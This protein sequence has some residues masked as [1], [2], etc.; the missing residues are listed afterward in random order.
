L[1]SLAAAALLVGC[2]APSKLS[3]PPAT[4]VTKALNGLG[5]LRGVQ[6]V[7]QLQAAGLADPS[8]SPA[9]A[10]A[11]LATHLVVTV[12]TADGRSLAGEGS[13]PHPEANIDVALVVRGD[14]VAELRTVAHK[15]YGRIDFPALGTQLALPATQRSALAHV[16]TMLRQDGTQAPGLANLA[17]GQWVDLPESQVLSVGTQQLVRLGIPLAP[18]T[19]RPATFGRVVASIMDV[20][21]RSSAADTGPVKG[22]ESYSASLPTRDL[23]SSPLTTLAALAGTFGNSA[24]AERVIGAAEAIPPAATVQVNFVVSGNRVAE[25]RLPLGQLLPNNPS[26]KDA[27][28]VADVSPAADVTVPSPST[29]LDLVQLLRGLTQRVGG[30]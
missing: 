10:Q 15:V 8:L 12:H 18:T 29:P 20:I 5:Q 27:Q 28:I 30:V 7:V 21:S 26:V 24:T 6:A 17:A 13:S 1:A 4:V 25:G 19:L 9:E 11:I 16:Q 22:G 3:G 14:N 2:G 23:L